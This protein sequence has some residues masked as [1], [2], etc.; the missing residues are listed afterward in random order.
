M[1]GLE[2]RKTGVMTK[3]RIIL[4]SGWK[5]WASHYVYPNV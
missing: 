5:F 3:I 2:N 4:K 1:L